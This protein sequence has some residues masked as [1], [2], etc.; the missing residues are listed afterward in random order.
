MIKFLRW[1]WLKIYFGLNTPRFRNPE[2][3]RNYIEYGNK[4]VW[5]RRYMEA[6]TSPSK[7]FEIPFPETTLE[8][9]LV[10]DTEDGPKTIAQM[11]MSENEE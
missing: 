9:E 3:E 8:D 4:P 7:N 5:V 10:F 1:L 11:K 6:P 2:S